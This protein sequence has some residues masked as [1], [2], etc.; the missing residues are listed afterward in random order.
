MKRALL[1]G[2]D[3]YPRGSLIGC[4]ADATAANELLA[5]NADG[6]AN[7]T[8]NVITSDNTDPITRDVLRRA[9][10]KLFEN[11]RDYDLLFFFAG[12][13]ARTP[14]GA[15][16]VTED[17]TEFSLGVSMHD[18]ITLAN[19]SPAR[20]VT[21]MLDCCFSGATGSI[22]GTQAGAVA[23][24]FRLTHATL[25]ENVTIMA[26]SRGTETSKE[27]G[28]HGAFTRVLLDGLSGGATDHLG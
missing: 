24:S 18:L 13:G 19:E 22:P 1:V 27:S 26:A 9:I 3:R 5:R 23:D 10:Y 7:W 16:L 6:N 21:I 12:H 15:E 2:I 20:S 17:F 25:R 4:V 14:W 11:A 28:G 8:T